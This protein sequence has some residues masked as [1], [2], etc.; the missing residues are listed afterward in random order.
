MKKLIMVTVIA[1]SIVLKAPPALNAQDA[2]SNK[3]GAI[4]NADSKAL[5]FDRNALYLATR[6]AIYKVADAKD[7]WESVF[8]LPAGENE[9]TCLAGNGEYLYAG[10]KR[11]LF[12]SNDRGGRWQNVFRT[13][14]PEKANILCV[15]TFGRASVLVGTERGIFLSEDAGSRWRDISF[16]LKN[17]AIRCIGRYNGYTFAGGDP[18]LYLRTDGSDRWERLVVMS[19]IEK[20]EA[21]D[22]VEAEEPGESGQNSITCIMVRGS[23][24]YVSLDKKI[25]YSDDNG[26]SWHAFTLQ[27]LAGSINHMLAVPGTERFYCATTSGVFE[28]SK[29]E[30]R[31]CELYKGTDKRMAVRRLIV[32]KDD[33]RLIW[34]ATDRGLYKLESGRYELTGYVDMDRQLK[35]FAVISGGE[36]TYLELQ[37]AAMRHAD[38][39]PEKIRGWYRQSRMRAL[40]PKVSVGFDNDSSTNYEIY[41]SATKDYIVSGPEDRSSGWDVSISWE[42]GD[43]IWSDDQTNIDVRSRLMVQLRN[44]IL[45]ELRHVYYERKRVQFELVTQPPKDIRARFEKEMRLEELTR[46]IDDLTGNYLS[47]YMK[48]HE[49]LLA[50]KK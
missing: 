42:L 13:I 25:I 27:G 29:A 20:K 19:A 7:K 18:G 36:P 4:K 44:D 35:T 24:L 34:A 22:A 38:V 2:W 49:A 12:R 9:I 16:N 39:S 46:A 6:N 23:R 48:K 43:I 40:L 28:F 8:Y 50:Q 33:E 30:Q 10:T 47:E 45:D 17:R 14:V 26:K 11:G 31:W 3:S 5:Y 1:I 37:K 41:T 21:A 15:E 32:D